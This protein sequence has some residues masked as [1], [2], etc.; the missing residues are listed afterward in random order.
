V[1]WLNLLAEDEDDI[2]I[3]RG[4]LVE[5]SIHHAVRKVE[6]VEELGGEGTDIVEVW[7]YVD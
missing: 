5:N 4:V 1:P 3:A 7:E 2:P 6:S